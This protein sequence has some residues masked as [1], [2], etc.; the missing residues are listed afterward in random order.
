M[1]VL[2]FVATAY[3][4][5]VDGLVFQELE[6]YENSLLFGDF[7]LSLSV[8]VLL[9]LRLMVVLQ[10][11]LVEYPLVVLLVQL[12]N[13]DARTALAL[14]EVVVPFSVDGA[15]AVRAPAVALTNKAL[16]HLAV[17]IGFVAALGVPD[18]RESVQR[19]E[20]VHEACESPRFLG[21]KEFLEQVYNL[22]R[23]VDRV[24]NRS[25]QLAEIGVFV[26]ER[27]I[28]H[29]VLSPRT[30]IIFQRCRY[31]PGVHQLVVHRARLFANFTCQGFQTCRKLESHLLAFQVCGRNDV[32]GGG[33]LG[34]TPIVVFIRL[35]RLYFIRA[36]R[37]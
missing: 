29:R 25:E 13:R 10:L 37:Q 20:V 22:L 4:G 35:N 19:F 36:L 14:A 3:L 7:F 17:L 28:N 18:P 32:S 1:R 15:A 2:F 9:A 26:V 5:A 30:S 6:G 31:C 16:P 12:T 27:W 23:T 8:E 21:L 24:A 11:R 34:R 33:R